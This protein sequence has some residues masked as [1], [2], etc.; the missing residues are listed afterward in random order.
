MKPFEAPD[1]PPSLENLLS[2]S[3]E[4]LILDN[5]LTVVF[6]HN[7]QQPIVSAQAW[8]KTGS[9]HEGARVG[10]GLSHFLEHMLFKGTGRRPGG[11]I[12]REVQSFGGDI[13]AYTAFDRTV[14]YINGPAEELERSLDLLHD[15]TLNATLPPEEVKKEQGVILREIDMTL[16]DPDRIVS[17][18]LFSTA[19]REHPFRYPVIGLRP[20]FEQVDREMLASY[21]HSRY[22]PNNM[23]VSVVGDFERDALVEAIGKTFGSAPRGTHEAPVL[24]EEPVQLAQRENRMSGDYRTARGLMAFK[25]PSMRHE[26]APALDILATIVGSGQ[27]GRLRQ[28]LRQDMGLVHEISASVWNPGNPGLFFIRYQCD[29]DKAAKAEE[30]IRATFEVYAETGFTEQEVEKARRFAF[31]SEVQSRQTVSGLAS[32]LGMITALLGDVQ[33]PRRYFQ[34][35]QSISAESLKDLSLRT[36]HPDRLSI[37]TLLPEDTEARI[38]PRPGRREVPE[39]EESVLSNG[40]R[41]YWQRDPRLPRTFMRL[42]G[43]GGPLYEDPQYKGATSLLTTIL[44]RDTR[45]KT[46]HQVAQDLELNGGFLNGVS[47]NNTFAMIAEVIPEMALE[48]IQALQDALFH[49]AFKPTTLTRER[50]AQLARLRELEDDI[51]DL[52]RMALRRRFFGDHPFSAEPVGTGESIARLD[53]A[54]L[55]SLYKRLFVASNTVLVITGDFDPDS[56][57]PH[58]ESFLS[59]LNDWKF[60]SLRNPFEAPAETGDASEIA[61]REQA[62]VFEAYPDC[63]FAPEADLVGELLDELLSDMSGPLFTAVREDRSLAYFVGASRLLSRDFGCFHLYAG[64]QPGSTGQVFECFDA[65]LDR[66][67]SGEVK[68]EE[69]EAARTRLKV[70]NRFSLQNPGSRAGRVALNALFGKPIMDWLTYEERLEAIQPDDLTGYVKDRLVPEKRLRYTIGPKID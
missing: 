60:R 17:R 43:L 59:L 25:V 33:Y 3:P 64:T 4:F 11:Q 15:M 42:A 65:E 63:G 49:P 56:L 57:L 21:Y 66:I 2:D 30:A 20:L 40:A 67:R 61:N 55:K 32:K 54:Y 31:V 34:K 18:S 13:N 6:Q 12:A 44:S 26:E 69:L 68:A 9:I 58:A 8:V 23:V 35:I 39:F 14:Y 22:Q 52:G 48:G 27:S 47:G 24:P 70:H 53:V 50:D 5:G 38:R 51:L 28:K 62:V 45:Y 10:S 29:P 41:I 16:D 19:Y 36:F 7:P 46:A 37:A 1:L